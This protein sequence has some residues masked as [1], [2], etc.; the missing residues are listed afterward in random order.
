MRIKD[1]SLDIVR[2][3]ESR[4]GDFLMGVETGHS[5]SSAAPEGLLADSHQFQTN[6]HLVIRR[7]IRFVQPEPSDT[8]IVLGCAKG[9]ALC[10]F[11][12]VPVRKVVGIE[13]S[14]P[15]AEI[16]K[17]NAGRLHKRKSPIDVRITDAAIADLSEAS[18]IYMFNPFGE[19]TLR[20]VLTRVASSH[21][22]TK[23][24]LKIVYLNPRF[25]NVFVDFPFFKLTREIFSWTGLRINIY[26]AKYS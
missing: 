3:L 15:L 24:S 6:S 10:H 2:A 25:S 19:N 20:R 13:I 11:A 12:R 5:G 4:V 14:A 21:R 9:R 18:L 8:V 23:K 7:V 1:K 22:E 17:Q 16:A 26:E